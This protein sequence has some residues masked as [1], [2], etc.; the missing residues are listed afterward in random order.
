MKSFCPQ[1]Y[2]ELR[3]HVECVHADEFKPFTCTMCDFGGNTKSALVKHF[4]LSHPL[5]RILVP[6][7]LLSQLTNRANSNGLVIVTF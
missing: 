2:K 3:D 7:A 4:Q 5:V 6:L 1:T